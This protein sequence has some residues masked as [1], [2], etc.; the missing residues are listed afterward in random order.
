TRLPA[1]VELAELDTRYRGAV[2]G[3][4]K[5]SEW[6]GTVA[7]A[8][9]G[10]RAQPQARLRHAQRV[11]PHGSAHDLSGRVGVF[12]QDAQRSQDHSAPVAIAKSIAPSPVSARR[13]S[14]SH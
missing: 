2:D 1:K 10:R 9:R 7:R 4:A 14:S 11:E 8:A 3:D 5:A 12:H 13:R 6:D